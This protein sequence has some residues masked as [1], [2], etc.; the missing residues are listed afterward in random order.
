[1]IVK[2]PRSKT[3]QYGMGRDV[4]ISRGGSS[5]CPVKAMKKWLAI[6]GVVKGRVFRRVHKTGTIGDQAITGGMI[7]RIV[8]QYAER[9]GKDASSFG[10]HSLRRGCCTA[11][12]RAG[13]SEAQMMQITGHRS[14]AQLRGYIEDAELFA[15]NVSSAR[16]GYS[17]RREVLFNRVQ[18]RQH[19][20]LR[21]HAYQGHQFVEAP[22][23]G[24]RRNREGCR[25][26]KFGEHFVAGA[27]A[28][29]L[30]DFLGNS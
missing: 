19:I 14:S 4:P 24:L 13:L 7:A 1:M 10:A 21:F 30:L 16:S 2:L 9:I 29:V 15:V 3:D 27:V 8:Q 11:M 5:L 25:M 17:V 20:C 12:A 23:T 6:S 28:L 22:R 26:N 18:N